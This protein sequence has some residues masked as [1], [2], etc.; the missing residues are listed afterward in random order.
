MAEPPNL[1]PPRQ[2]TAAPDD[3][4]R[5]DVVLTGGSVS[6]LTDAPAFTFVAPA[7]MALPVLIAVPHGG[8]AYCDDLLARMRAPE[9]SQVRLEDRHVDRLGGAIAEGVAAALLTA[10]A[11]RAALDLNRAETDVDWGMIEGPRLA[12]SPAGQSVVSSNH[13]A[14]SGLGLIPRRLPGHGEVWRSRLPRRELERRIEHIHQPYHQTLGEQL[15]RIRDIWGAALLIDLHSMPP[16]PTHEVDVP[17][18]RIV[19]GDRFGASCHHSLMSRGLEHL[20]QNGFS[21]TQNRPYSGGYV[22]D[23]HGAPLK[24]IHAIQIEICRSLYLDADMAEL[25]AHAEPLAMRLSCLVQELGRHTAALGQAR[26]I[27]EA[28]E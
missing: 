14:R 1:P 21:A 26:A 19:L 16:L 6:A 22:L 11:P 7:E 2:S 10:H 12:R 9:I 20:A 3:T 28:A 13:R 25:T 18:P 17:P 24:G 27:L 23:R 15:C 8:R 5:A 4:E